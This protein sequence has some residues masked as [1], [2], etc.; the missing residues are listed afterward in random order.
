VIWELVRG[1]KLANLEIGLIGVVATHAKVR[2]FALAQ[3][4]KG[5]PLQRLAQPPPS[6]RHRSAGVQGIV[7]I[8]ITIARGQI[9]DHGHIAMQLGATV[10]RLRD[11]D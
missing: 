7:Y 1:K 2:N 10:V 3:S 4:P 11:I 8:T 9:G 5:T 6:D